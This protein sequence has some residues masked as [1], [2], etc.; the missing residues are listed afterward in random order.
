MSHGIAWSQ[1]VCRSIEHFTSL[2]TRGGA[3]QRTRD[4]AYFHWS[5][6][7]MFAPSAQVG[8]TYR[9]VSGLPR[10]MA[11]CWSPGKMARLRTRPTSSHLAQLYLRQQ[12]PR[13]PVRSPQYCNMS[14]N[15]RE[16]YDVGEGVCHCSAVRGSWD[17][18]CYSRI[19]SS[20][21]CR[22]SLSGVRIQVAECKSCHHSTP[23]T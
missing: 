10:K 20:T 18:Q 15:A 13:W 22:L 5:L 8:R 12:P 2:H 19:N 9:G 11:Q 23:S 14:R 7:M 21:A 4:C 1:P 17:I 16:L 6:L 3:Y